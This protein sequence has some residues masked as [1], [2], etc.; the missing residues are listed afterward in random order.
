MRIAPIA[1]S[2]DFVSANQ[3]S[4]GFPLSRIVYVNGAFLPEADA[5]ISIFDRGFLFADGVYEVCAVLAGGLVDNGGHLRRLRRSLDELQM[6]SPETDAG[7]LQ[8]QRELIAR[9]QLREGLIYLQIT[10]GVADRD[11]AYPENTSPTLIMFTQSKPVVDNPLAATGISVITTPDIRWARRDIKTV[12]LLPACM[13]KML[14]REAA[15]DDAW[16]VEADHVTE[17]SSSN[18][19]IL[20]AAGTL[21]TRHLDRGILHG[22][23]RQAVLR[24]AA[25]YDIDFEQRPFSV[26]EAYQAAE[27]FVTSASALV[28]PV[29]RIDDRPVGTGSPGPISQRLR[30]LYIEEARTTLS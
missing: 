21:V 22:I 3:R 17:G 5:K 13:A 1:S 7:I 24:L 23:T 8:I 29:I 6:A 12:G 2:I 19:F 18:A 30:T 28:L 14:A 26:Q 9:N 25:E 27:A 4:G 15:A 16:M 20:T 10:R 11:F